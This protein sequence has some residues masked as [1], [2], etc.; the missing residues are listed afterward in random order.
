M[1][2]DLIYEGFT[3]SLMMYDVLQARIESVTP[4]SNSNI[5]YVDGY[6]T[7]RYWELAPIGKKLYHYINGY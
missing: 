7:L 3:S 4:A 5:R 6:R 1:R 2:N